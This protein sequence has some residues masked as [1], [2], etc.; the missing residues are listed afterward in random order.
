[1]VSKFLPT[2]AAKINCTFAKLVLGSSDVSPLPNVTIES[3]PRSGHTHIENC[4]FDFGKYILCFW[5]CLEKVK[6]RSNQ[7]YIIS[8]SGLK[9]SPKE[10]KIRFQSKVSRLP[11]SLGYNTSV[12]Q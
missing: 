7:L 4:S 2:E 3:T 5:I 6:K 1:M 11:T 12:I 10:G 8:K 9:L